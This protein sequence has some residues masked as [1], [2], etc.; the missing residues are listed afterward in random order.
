MPSI[1]KPAYF[2]QVDN[3]CEAQEEE[4]CAEITRAGHRLHQLVIEESYQS[5]EDHIVDVAV[6]IDGTWAKRGLKSLIGVTIVISALNGEVL[7]NHVL[8]KTCQKSP[9]KKTECEGD[10]ER[11]E[12]WRMEHITA[13]ECDTN[14]TG[15]SPV[16][17]EGAVI[18]IYDTQEELFPE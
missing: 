2:K 7:D 8:S 10:E 12:K 18:L 11:L 6:S 4:V 9:N 13:G 16:V 15:I 17:A 3:I 1:S 14:F 5:G